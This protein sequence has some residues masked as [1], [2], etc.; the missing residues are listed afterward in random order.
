M[1]RQWVVQ[2]QEVGT[3]LTSAF[4]LLRVVGIA[5]CLLAFAG[6]VMAATL[7]FTWTDT[8]DN[9]AGFQMERQCDGTL[10]FSDVGA[11][12]GPNVTTM[13]LQQ[14][15]DLICNYRLRAFNPAGPSGPSNVVTFNS[16]IVPNAPSGLSLSAS[17]AVSHAQSAV[18]SLK[19]K[20]TQAGDRT[21]I[22]Q[23]TQ[24]GNKLAGALTLVVKAEHRLE[25]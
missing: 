12:V 14:A 21:A 8:S 16:W 13:Q 24:A 20:A 25:Q 23:T 4:A 6:R 15:K 11:S 2:G 9:E 7:T 10:G 1:G 5:L 17:V 22:S 3:S 19:H 18:A